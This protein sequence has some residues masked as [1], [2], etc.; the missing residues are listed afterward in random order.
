MAQI[1]AAVD[2][3]DTVA[4]VRA[5]VDLLVASSVPERQAGPAAR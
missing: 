1:I 2:R 3:L 5:V 4:D